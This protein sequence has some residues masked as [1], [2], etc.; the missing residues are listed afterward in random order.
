MK[1]LFEK[2]T[3]IFFILKYKVD[4]EENIIFL[5]KRNID[6]PSCKHCIMHKHLNIGLLKMFRHFKDIKCK[7]I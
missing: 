4:L 5:A 7:D 6:C 2:D 3:T 1:P